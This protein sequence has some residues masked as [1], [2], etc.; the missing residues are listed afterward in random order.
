VKKRESVGG[1]VK[2]T[3]IAPEFAQRE[4]G[5]VDHA[6][7]PPQLMGVKEQSGTYSEDPGIHRSRKT[8]NLGGTTQRR[9]FLCGRNRGGTAQTVHPA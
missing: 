9:C 1:K 8:K 6:V 7:T 4:D 3:L 5:Q 2:G